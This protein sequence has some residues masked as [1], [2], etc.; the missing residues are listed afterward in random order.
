MQERADL[1]E[2]VERLEAEAAD[3]A[4]MLSAE[5]GAVQAAAV[6]AR[7]DKLAA[8]KVGVVLLTTEQGVRGVVGVAASAHKAR[9]AAIKG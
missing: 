1:V 4:S 3:H 8:E 2:K 7:E 6:T 9:L 5:A